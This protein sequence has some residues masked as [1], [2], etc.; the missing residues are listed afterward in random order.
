MITRLNTMDGYIDINADDSFSIL[1]K[2]A[3]KLYFD[4]IHKNSDEIVKVFK[5]KDF[6]V[7]TK[8]IVSVEIREDY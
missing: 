2:A 7:N 6:Q 8:D 3:H 1:G 5:S 4:L